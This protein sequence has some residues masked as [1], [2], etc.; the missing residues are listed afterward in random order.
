LLLVSKDI[1]KAI[2]DA[3]APTESKLDV[4]GADAVNTP[5]SQRVVG[6][7]PA[8]RKLLAG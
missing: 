7:I 3:T 2:A 4:L 8:Q 6:K 1:G 5:L